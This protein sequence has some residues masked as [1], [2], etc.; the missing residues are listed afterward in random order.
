MLHQRTKINMWVDDFSG[1]NVQGHGH[2]QAQNAP[3]TPPNAQNRLFPQNLTNFGG[4]D[5]YPCYINQI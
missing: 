2:F 3:K 4:K 5:R 1:F